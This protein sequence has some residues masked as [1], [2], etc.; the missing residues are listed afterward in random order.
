MISINILKRLYLKLL[1]RIVLLSLYCVLLFT[2]AYERCRSG[3]MTLL[4]L[5]NLCVSVVWFSLIIDLAKVFP[6]NSPLS[7]ILSLPELHNM[8]SYCSL[9]LASTFTCFFFNSLSIH[10]SWKLMKMKARVNQGVDFPRRAWELL[11]KRGAT[12]FEALVS[13]LLGNSKKSS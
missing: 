10:F 9:C 5:I 12:T 8:F 7:W 4:Y 2:K 11:I 1:K 6:K 13:D 3:L